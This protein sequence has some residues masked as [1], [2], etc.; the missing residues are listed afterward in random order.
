MERI[1]CKKMMRFLMMRAENFLV[2]RRKPVEVCTH[3]LP[4][5]IRKC[6]SYG[7]RACVFSRLI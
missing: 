5:Q 6:N 3:P 4:F 7:D 1:L 2:L